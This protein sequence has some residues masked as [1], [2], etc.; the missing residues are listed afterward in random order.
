[1][2]QIKSPLETLQHYCHLC[3]A[4]TLVTR[5][6]NA[7]MVNF[8]AADLTRNLRFYRL[9]VT[10]VTV[11]RCT[12]MFACVNFILEKRTSYWPFAQIEHRTTLVES[13]REC[14]FKNWSLWHCTFALETSI[15]GKS[16]TDSLLRIDIGKVLNVCV[17]DTNQYID[18]GNINTE[19][20]MAIYCQNR[21]KKF[22]NLSCPIKGVILDFVQIS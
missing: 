21:V 17:R 4:L 8:L 19:I 3:R 6:W 15:V 7:N 14:T 18:I 10:F 13:I 11:A 5:K 12:M 20:L 16:W 2:V 22:S 1:M 9:H